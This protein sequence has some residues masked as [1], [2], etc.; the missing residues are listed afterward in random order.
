MSDPPGAAVELRDIRKSFGGT[1]ALRGVTFVARAG[2]VTAL[3]GEN[4]A[5]KS[6]LLRV[7]SGVTPA[8]AGN[9]RLDGQVRELRSPKEAQAAGIAIIHQELSVLP[10]LSVAENVYLSRLP[11]R[12]MFLDWRRLTADCRALLDRVGVRIDPHV[13]VGHLSLARQQLVEIARALALD[14]HVLAMDE[15]TASLSDDEVRNLFRVIRQLRDEGRA[16]I[17]ISHRLD[18]VFEIA[19]HIT[20]LRDGQVVGTLSRAAATV[21]RV[22]SM[23]VGRP[24]DQQFPK[25]PTRPGAPLLE[26]RDVWTRELLRGVSLVVHRGEIVGLAGLVGAGRTE[27]A[28]AIFGA[29][30][31]ERGAIVLDGQH[32]TIRNPGDAV[33]FGIGFLTEDRKKSGLIL[34]FALFRNHTLPS[35]SKFARAGQLIERLEVEA[36]ARWAADLRI[37]ARSPYQPAHDLSGGNQQKVVLGKWLE[38]NPRLLILDEPTRGVDVGAKVEIYEI[39]NRLAAAG[40]AILMI[41]SDL[42]EVLGMSDRI[43]VMHEGRV[44][45]EFQRAEATRESVIK[46]AIA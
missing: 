25:Q 19:D 26:V 37:R 5:G 24:I 43:V 33:Q 46:A 30:P 32:V 23:M 16:I 20:V 1:H 6:T 41:S 13:R 45:G 11:L 40:A 4:G 2:E 12:G 28:R 22:V 17:F 38:R 36:F 34:N 44:T 39:M 10:Y 29:D 15:P 14:A 8:D 27:L 18:E 3:V 21:E 35:L 42:P 9:I 31:I 7:L